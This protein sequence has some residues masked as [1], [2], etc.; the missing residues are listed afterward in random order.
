MA[1][2]HPD[3]T[4]ADVAGVAD[5]VQGRA[6]AVRRGAAALL[7][8]LVLAALVGLLGV[9]TSEVSAQ[10]AGYTLTATYPAI[11]RAGLDTPWEVTVTADEGFG[12]EITL[13][14]TGAYFDLFET[15]GFHPEP[16]DSTRDG[17]TLYLTFTAPESDTFVVAYDAYIQPSSQRGAE[18]TVA[19]VDGTTPLVEVRYRTRLL[20]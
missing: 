19:V 2:S 18:A 3:S 17:S 12:K 16:A 7:T 15:Q 11:A 1:M 9:R 5:P 8:L 4:L 6:F 14:V 13:A 10:D 20:P